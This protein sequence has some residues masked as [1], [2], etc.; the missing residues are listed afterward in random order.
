MVEYAQSKPAANAKPAFDGEKSTW[1]DGFTRYDYLMDEE[2]MAVTPFKVPDGEKFGVK[3][4]PRVKRRCIVIAPK[5]PAPGNPWT[6][7][8]C[9]WDHQPGAEI[10]LLR[11]GFHVAYISANATLRPSK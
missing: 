3:D 6:W 4:P 8:G 1:H 5:E 9:Y 2:T 7:R 10:E 11:R